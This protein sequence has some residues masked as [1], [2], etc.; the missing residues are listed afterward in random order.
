MSSNDCCEVKAES[1]IDRCVSRLRNNQEEVDEL[2]AKLYMRLS[3]IIS[4]EAPSEIANATPPDAPAP[5]SSHAL[6]LDLLG[7]RSTNTV[8]RLASLI[9]RIEL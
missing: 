8:R 4:P 2:V 5:I 3:P 9:T 6:D 1:I 7:D